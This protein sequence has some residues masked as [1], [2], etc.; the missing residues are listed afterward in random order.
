MSDEDRSGFSDEDEDLL[1]PEEAEARIQEFLDASDREPGAPTAELVDQAIGH[2]RDAWE[3]I[4]GITSAQSNNK[5]VAMMLDASRRG[6]EL[7]PNDDEHWIAH[8]AST[9]LSGQIPRA[10]E[11]A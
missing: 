7:D 6:R 4:A 1:T 3:R 8:A 9:I 5:V 10:R 11:D 2:M